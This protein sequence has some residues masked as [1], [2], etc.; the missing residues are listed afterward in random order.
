MYEY[1]YCTLSAA[2]SCFAQVLLLSVS[3]NHNVFAFLLACECAPSEN[4]ERFSKTFAKTDE[5]TPLF[6]A[7][8]SGPGEYR[9]RQVHV[10]PILAPAGR[11]RRRGPEPPV[12]QSSPTPSG[13]L[14]STTCCHCAAAPCHVES[15]VLST[16]VSHVALCT[17]LYLVVYSDENSARCSSPS[18]T[19]LVWLSNMTVA[20]APETNG[21]NQMHQ[22][23][24]YVQF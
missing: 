4:L 13:E 12:T 9:R 8:A 23:Y 3:Q 6:L 5:V 20:Y 2:F 21:P 18:K 15:L 17:L 11:Q 10:L 24:D 22:V 19:S 16:C 1:T 14:H 7:S